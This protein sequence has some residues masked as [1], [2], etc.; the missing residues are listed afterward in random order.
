MGADKPVGTYLPQRQAPKSPHGWLKLST[1]P[2]YPH[3]ATV[4]CRWSINMQL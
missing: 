1:Y 4:D 2:I 3:Y